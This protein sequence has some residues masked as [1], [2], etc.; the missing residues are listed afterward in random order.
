[1]KNIFIIFILWLSTPIFLWAQ[2]EEELRQIERVAQYKDTFSFETPPE[3]I[4]KKEVVWEKPSTAF[5]H[6]VGI[7]TGAVLSQVFRLFGLVKDTQSFP[8]SS[9]LA[10]YKYQYSSRNVIRVGIGGSFDTNTE[11]QGGFADSKKITTNKLSIRL[12]Y[13]RQIPLDQ[14][15]TVSLGGDVIY[16][17]NNQFKEFDS[18]FDQAL[19]ISHSSSWGLGPM[20]GIRY[21]FSPRVSIGCEMSLYLVNSRLQERDE[22][23]TNPSFNREVRLSTSSN[24]QFSGPSNVYL[25][26]RF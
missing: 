14:R 10:Y 4:I 11:Q 22:F 7:E 20:T 12:G 2:T 3:K 8:T 9:Y 26:V 18:G 21:N 25:S 13:E 17:F 1:M 6:E 15:W 5:K 19:R 23:S 24:I 16:G